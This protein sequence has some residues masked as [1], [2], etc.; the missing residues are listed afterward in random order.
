MVR[1]TTIEDLRD[2]SKRMDSMARKQTYWLSFT[3]GTWK[4]FRK[5]GISTAKFSDKE[6]KNHDKKTGL[7]GNRDGINCYVLKRF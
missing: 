3:I 5:G 4:L 1:Q 2:M 6:F 7:I